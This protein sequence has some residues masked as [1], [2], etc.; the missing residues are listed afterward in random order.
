MTTAV[1]AKFP[2]S[3]RLLKKRDFKFTD[4]RRVQTDCFGFV[5]QK[6]GHGRLGISISKK[7]LRN[8]AARARVRRLLREV[9]RLRYSDF[10]G[11]DVHVI[12]LNRLLPLWREMKLID[13]EMR[14]DQFLSNISMEKKSVGKE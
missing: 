7:V 14:F 13:V 6:N 1:S 3:S 5:Y 10:R 2:K 9:F 8:A 4:Y 12:G 11:L